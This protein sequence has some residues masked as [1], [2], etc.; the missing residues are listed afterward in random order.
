[1]ADR[2]SATPWVVAITAALVLIGGFPMCPTLE[3]AKAVLNKLKALAAKKAG[4]SESHADGPD[5]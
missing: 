5:G 4:V 1:M 2:K 3:F